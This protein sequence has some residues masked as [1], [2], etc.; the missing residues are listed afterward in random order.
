MSTDT[1]LG[2]RVVVLVCL[3]YIMTIYRLQYGGWRRHYP[4][5]PLP[6]TTLFVVL[7][8]GD[9]ILDYPA[10]RIVK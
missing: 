6:C 4:V 8:V 1:T 5:T 9:F 2:N 7:L 3:K 10:D